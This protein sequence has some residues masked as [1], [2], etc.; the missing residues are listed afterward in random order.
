MGE[1]SS[2]NCSFRKNKVETTI[3]VEPPPS[4]S[5]ST[6]SP[7]PTPTPR[8]PTTTQAVVN[9][10]T[11]KTVNKDGE[12]FG[13]LSRKKRERERSPGESSEGSAS[14]APSVEISL[15]GLWIKW[16]LMRQNL[17]LTKRDSNQSPQLWRPTRNLKICLWQVIEICLWQV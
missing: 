1:L 9:G 14:A 6:P 12:K 5:A 2:L 7:P 11:Q 4:T 10:P 16:G 17:F 8:T 3:G 15:K 13:S